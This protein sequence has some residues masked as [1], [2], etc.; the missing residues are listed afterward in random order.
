MV[1]GLAQGGGEMSEQWRK[2]AV[3][4]EFPQCPHQFGGWCIVCVRGA[5]QKGLDDS[6]NIAELGRG[7]CFDVDKGIL[8]ALG[9]FR[10]QIAD[11]I[12]FLG[13]KRD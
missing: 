9:S 11:R 13:G 7:F 12:R 2:T 8:N 4:F 3:S 5:Y 10:L 6:A 1:R